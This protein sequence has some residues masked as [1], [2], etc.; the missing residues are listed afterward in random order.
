MK[1]A[2]IRALNLRENEVEQEGWMVAYADLITLLFI[3]FSLMLSISV[4]SKAKFELL[5][6]QFN[7]KSTASLLELKK[8]L[9]EE[10]QKQN[11]QTQVQTQISEEG[12]KVQFN[13]SVLFGSGDATLNPGTGQTISK[14]S[15]LLATMPDGF[16]LAIEGH[17]DDRPIHSAAFPSNWSLSASRAV[18]VLHLLESQGIAAGKMMVKAYADTRPVG[19]TVKTP[20]SQ[21]DFRAQNRRVTLLIY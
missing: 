11:L 13:E 10:I 8:H 19:N 16:H 17:T 7:Q 15:H 4:I 9:D 12:L 2:D 6:H 5:T 14:F 3:F 1:I 18:N 20:D 21:N